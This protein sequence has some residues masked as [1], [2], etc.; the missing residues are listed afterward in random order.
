MSI[1]TRARLAPAV[2]AAPAVPLLATSCAGYGMANTS[3]VVTEAL[4]DP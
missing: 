4:V 1:R 3:R 2:A